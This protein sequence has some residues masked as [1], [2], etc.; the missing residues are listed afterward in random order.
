LLKENGTFDGSTFIAGCRVVVIS[1][2][3]SS[4]SSSSWSRP[5]VPFERPFAP[6]GDHV[7]S[8][9]M[10]T[11]STELEVFSRISWT[12]L[13]KLSHSRGLLCKVQGFLTDRLPNLRIAQPCCRLDN[14]KLGLVL[15]A[16]EMT[17]RRNTDCECMWLSG[18]AE[19]FW[20]RKPGP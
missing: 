13:Y 15:E 2:K 12:Y 9:S 17:K 16:V 20:C 4:E 6:T 19:L 11:W 14:S 5:L 10:F 18:L 3:S 7:E 1:T 8:G